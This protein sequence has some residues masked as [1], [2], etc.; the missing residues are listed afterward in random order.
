MPWEGVAVESNVTDV[1][2][3]FE[4]GG[5]RGS[6][7]S[8]VVVELLRA[9]IYF[10]WVAG[11]SAGSSN[12]A[13][14][15]ARD[16]HRARASFVEFAADPKMGNMRTW[17]KG[18]G[19]F[20]SEYIY[21]QTGYPGQALPYD[22]TTFQDNPARMRIGSFRVDT[23]EAVY[24]TKEDTPTLHDLMVRVR[25]SSSMPVL[26]PPV[27]VGDAVYLDGALGPSGGIPLDAAR[28]DGFTKFL[29]ILTRP[30][31]YVKQP[32][33]FTAAL[34]RYF[35]KYP[36][37]AD[38]IAARPANYNRTREELF[39]LERTGQAMLFVP[40]EMPVENGERNVVKLAASHQ[41]GRAQA[42]RELPRWREWLGVSA[43]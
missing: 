19:W 10:D 18:Q 23:G 8:A 14:Y 26:M 31:T 21:E 35:R 41:L 34:K 3:V 9:G 25:A 20:N 42:Q 36:A 4:G 38:A 30:R 22:F 17:L 13:N 6:Y 29:V 43:S 28:A 24:W 1:A 15:L 39:E 11:I 40:E 27:T 32:V 37:V 7:T 2:L 5:M 16:A 33:K 12:T